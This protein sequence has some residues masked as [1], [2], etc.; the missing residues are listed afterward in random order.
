MIFALVD[1]KKTKA[2]KGL[3]GFCPVCN[4]KLIPVCSEYRINHWRHK[5]NSECDIWS[6]GETEWHMKWKSYFPEVNQEVIIIKNAIKHIADIYTENST[7]IELQN[8]PIADAEI[9]ERNV[10]Y[11]KI[12]W[13]VNGD[14]FR[15]LKVNF[16]NSIKSQ[17]NDNVLIFTN[18]SRSKFFDKWIKSTRKV[19]IDFGQKMVFLLL[20]YDVNTKI[21][22]VKMI[23]KKE[24]LVRN[25]AIRTDD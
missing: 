21:G 2:Q 13:I 23:D 15:F 12:F 18:Y 22:K 25:K 24:L 4:E 3:I 14:N 10:F 5:S 20:E 8:S 7:V 1:L 6:E 11:D 19:I 17:T 9:N 16:F